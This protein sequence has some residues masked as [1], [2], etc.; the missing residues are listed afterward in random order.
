VRGRI[1]RFVEALRAHDLPVSVAEAMDAVAAIAAAGVDRPVLRE[2]LAATLVKDEDDRAAFD[3]LFEAA[4]PLRAGAAGRRS[5][6]RDAGGGDGAASGPPRGGEG[7]GVGRRPKP[8]DAPPAAMRTATTRERPDEGRVDGRRAGEPRIGRAPG[9]H[10][11]S[12]GRR[13][14]LVRKPLHLFDPRDVEEARELVRELGA[15][16][17]GRLARRERRRVR[18]KVDVR[19]MLRASVATGGVPIRIVRRGRRP[20]RADLV[21]LVDLSGS[22][23]TASELC[24]GLIAPAA[25]YFRRVHTFAYVDHLCPVT[26]EGGHVTPDGPLDLHAR[27]DFGQV[28]GELVGT[29]AALLTRRALLLIVGDARNNRRPHRADLLAEARARVQRVVWLVPEPRARWN[30]GDSVLDRYAAASDAVLECDSLGALLSAL[31]R[32]L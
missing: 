19:R 5:A 6:R 24:L 23:A 30:T 1:L 10:R 28:L 14:E 29:R 12:R 20:A 27:S 15:R 7:G 17:R 32:T 11:Q 13:R 21:A 18:G 22:V 4:F 26:I 31:R 9:P 2:A 25:T 16:L 3:E 8:P